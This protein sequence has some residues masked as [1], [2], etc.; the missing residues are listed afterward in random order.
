MHLKW[1]RCGERSTFQAAQGHQTSTVQSIFTH[2]VH[3]LT[4]PRKTHGRCWV[5]LSSSPWELAGDAGRAHRPLCHSEGSSGASLPGPRPQQTGSHP[6]LL[7]KKC[8][9][10]HKTPFSP[11]CLSRDRC[12]APERW[13]NFCGRHQTLPLQPTVSMKGTRLLPPWA[14]RG[15]RAEGTR[16]SLPHRPTDPPQGSLGRPAPLPKG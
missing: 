13:M 15:D 11:I 3:S 4:V 10:P 16:P 12:N 1:Q 7:S 5:F 2:C 6:P 14:G 8:S 9:F